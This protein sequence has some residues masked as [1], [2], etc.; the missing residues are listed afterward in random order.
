[1]HSFGDTNSRS[2]PL[3]FIEAFVSMSPY[4]LK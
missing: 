2:F 1:M 3:S 4:L